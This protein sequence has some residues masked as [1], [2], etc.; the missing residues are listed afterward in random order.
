MLDEHYSWVAV[1][2]HFRAEPLVAERFRTADPPIEYYLPML[3]KRD[4]RC[5][6]AFQEQPMFPGY[7]FARINNKQ[8]YQTRTTRGVVAIVTSNHNIITV[9]QRDIDAVHAFENSRRK[10]FIHE[11]HRLVKGA[12]VMITQGEFAGL[13]GRMVR[14]CEDGNFC[15]N[16]EVMNLSFV[17]RLKRDELRPTTEEEMNDG[18]SKAIWK[19]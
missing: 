13:K 3:M 16:I 1:M 11:T 10:F 12:E 17:V 19:E 2:T 15:V 5:K 4:K 6:D 9:P 7:L 14:G 8:V 18:K